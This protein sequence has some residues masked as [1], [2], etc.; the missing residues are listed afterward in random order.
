[1]TDFRRYLEEAR[2]D[3][4]LASSIDI[5]ALLSTI[6]NEINP[7][8]TIEESFSDLDLSHEESRTLAKKL[9]EYDHIDEISGLQKGRHIRWIRLAS[10]PVYLTN[11]GILVDIKFLDTGTHILCMNQQRRFIQYK[12]DDCITYQ[13]MSVDEQLVRLAS[14]S[15]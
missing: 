5:D 11:G 8:S 1:M 7:Y 14:S 4:E 10:C 12:W 3:P 15:A 13:K 9:I 2:Q 6:T